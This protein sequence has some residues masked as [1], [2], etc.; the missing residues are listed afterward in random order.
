MNRYFKIY[1]LLPVL[2][3]FQSC[4]LLTTG[5]DPTKLEMIS[6]TWKVDIALIDNVVD[7]TNDYSGYRFEFRS[8]GSYSFENGSGSAITGTWELNSNETVMILD[9]DTDDE[10]EVNILEINEVSLIL[11]FS[12][13]ATFKDP[14]YDLVYELVL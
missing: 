6:K 8:D 14:A 10:T 11:Q 3:A 2:L 4:E 12:Y 9:E 7:N 5:G 1:I 13:A